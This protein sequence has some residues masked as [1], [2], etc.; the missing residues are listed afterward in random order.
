MMVRHS[1]PYLGQNSWD[2]YS[3]LAQLQDAGCLQK[4]GDFR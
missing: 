1:V 4:S 3:Y 2:L